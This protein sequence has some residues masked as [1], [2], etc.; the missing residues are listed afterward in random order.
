MGNEGEGVDM[1]KRKTSKA[2]PQRI[3]F[4]LSAEDKELF[5]RAA[6]SK[7]WSLT[8]LAK[9][10]MRRYARKMVAP[11]KLT[12]RDRDLFLSALDQFDQPNEALTQAYASYVASRAK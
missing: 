11:K 7:G 12:D 6:A 1:T 8:Y 10:S 4:R 9:Y 3:N 5:V 2:N